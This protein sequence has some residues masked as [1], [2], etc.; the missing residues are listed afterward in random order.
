MQALSIQNTTIQKQLDL[1]S[2]T[3]PALVLQCD[4]CHGNRPNGECA[5]KPTS[6]EQVNYMNVQRHNF[7]PNN[8]VLGYRDH[9]NSNQYRENQGAPGHSYNPPVPEKKSNLENMFQ[10]FM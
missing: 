10:Q 9:A 3:S 7:H 5:T 2:T 4:F 8:Y 1:L 6:D